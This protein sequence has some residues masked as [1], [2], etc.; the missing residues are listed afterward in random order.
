M[1]QS[2]ILSSIKWR[3]LPNSVAVIGE[4]CSMYKILS[5]DLGTL[6]VLHKFSFL[7]STFTV[8]S[9]ITEFQI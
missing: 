2:F 8:P 5:P 6:S 1:S 9:E 7:L 3:C 4:G